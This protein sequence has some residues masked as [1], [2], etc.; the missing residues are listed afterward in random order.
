MNGKDELIYTIGTALAALQVDYVHM[1]NLEEDYCLA[2]DSSPQDLEDWETHYLEELTQLQ[3]LAGPCQTMTDAE[4]AVQD[5]VVSV[6]VRG[7][8]R[9]LGS[10]QFDTSYK[11]YLQGAIIQ[12]ELDV[13][14]KPCSVRLFIRYADQP[15][16]DLEIQTLLDFANIIFNKE[17]S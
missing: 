16:E 15:L 14:G 10:E 7:D 3:Y 12:G 5:L 17:Q 11:I 1:A 13:T 9:D 8:W 4:Q 6:S 2:Q